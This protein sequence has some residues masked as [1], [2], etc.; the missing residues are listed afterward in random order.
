M[1]RQRSDTEVIVVVIVVVMRRRN[2]RRAFYSE[3]GHVSRLDWAGIALDHLAEECNL[4]ALRSLTVL[5]VGGVVRW[6]SYEI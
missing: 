4:N 1:I 6:R 5:K 3:A 2:L